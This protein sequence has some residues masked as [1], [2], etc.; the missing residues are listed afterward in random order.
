MQTTTTVSNDPSQTSCSPA[1]DAEYR[2]WLAVVHERFQRLGTEPIFTTDATGLYD[3][4]L[5]ALP[6]ERRQYY[7]C[8]TCRHFI[9]RFGALV[10]IDK[11]GVTRS[12][13]WGGCP[14]FFLGPVVAMDRIVRRAKVTGVFL[15][16]EPEL[17]RRETAG[18]DG[19]AWHHLAATQPRERIYQRMFATAEQAMAAKRED[20]HAVARALEEYPKHLVDE[21][22]RV[23]RSDVLFRSEKVTPP[24][25]WLAN[26]HAAREGLRGPAA[27]NVLWCAVATAPAGFCHPRSSMIGT[28]LDDLRAGMTFEAVARRFREKM[29]PLQ[30]QRPSAAPTAGAIAEAERIVEKLEIAR[31]LER[32]YARL[33]EVQT[34]W[35][36]KEGPPPAGTAGGVFG[37][38][39]P[40]GAVVE[41]PIPI[42]AITMTW[43]KF[44]R[45]ALPTAEKIE[46]YTSGI[47]DSYGA[48]V[49]AVHADAPPIL[50]WDHADFRNPVSWYVWAG[51]SFPTE[52]GLPDFAYIP[53]SGLAMKP[54]LWGPR[55]L[56][57]QGE[58]V[59]FL[60]A[61]AREK[62]PAPLGLFPEIL[63]AELHGVRSVIEAHSRSQRLEGGED[64]SACGL[65]FVKGLTRRPPLRLRVTSGE[66]TQEYDLDRWD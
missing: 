63:K 22:L 55:P 2:D 17:G 39:K 54:N 46:L 14:S 65:L 18:K 12:V 48:L 37:H 13:F 27:D 1:E 50:Q 62:R 6:P 23:L 45:V 36:P 52:W 7:T 51:G 42:P 57:H 41:K 47:R 29:D 21:A 9:E 11:K 61:G 4:F 10:T 26:L 20:H 31:S 38:L 35:S 56:A 3:A 28:L 24:A 25:E 59:F 15:S 33:E 5:G 53:V 66:A 43:E 8:R 40:K 58:G 32:R 60:L 44:R 34:F 30:Y 49:T 64:G 19:G 16:S